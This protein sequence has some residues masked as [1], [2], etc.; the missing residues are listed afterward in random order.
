MMQAVESVVLVLGRRKPLLE[1]AFGS[2]DGFRFVDVVAQS[3]TLADYERAADA[4]VARRPVVGVVA[5]SESTMQLAGYLRTRYGLDG[6]QFEQSLVVTDKWHM[7]MAVRSAV[8]SPRTWLSGQFLHERPSG[9]PEVVVKPRASSSARGVR[10]LS[11]M[12]A[13]DF[14]S[15]NDRLWVVAE[16]IDVEREF[17]CDG[18]VRDGSIA[19]MQSSEY[20]RPVL[21]SFGTRSTTV[22]DASDPLRDELSLFASAVISAIAIERGVFHL[23][24]MYDG[25]RLVFGEIGFRPAGTGIAEL[26]LRVNEIDL[27]AEFLAA[28]LGT[29]RAPDWTATDVRDVAGLIMARPGVNG[30]P[31][32]DES[33]A[34]SLPGVIG[35]GVGN[36]DRNTDPENMCEYEYLVFFD[37]VERS[38]VAD[39]RRAVAGKG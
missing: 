4:I 25:R 38:S 11:Y 15:S 9:L 27:W 14:L 6:L 37:G 18:V 2:L 28:Q 3:D 24:I 17:H 30:E 10:R 5:T 23:E 16:A 33:A 39:L 29:E 31:P 32:L 8:L 22:L 36:I 7:T 19:W 35:I 12:D 26:I 1:R 13:L 20:D 34:R 21:R